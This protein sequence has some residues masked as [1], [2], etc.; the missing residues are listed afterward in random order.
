MPIS[1]LEGKPERR[2][3]PMLIGMKWNR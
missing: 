3:A 2:F 1:L